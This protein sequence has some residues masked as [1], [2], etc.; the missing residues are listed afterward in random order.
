M[1]N[2]FLLLCTLLFANSLSAQNKTAIIGEFVQC[3]CDSVLIILQEDPVIHRFRQFSI[4]V[5]ENKFNADIAISEPSYFYIREG[6]RFITGLVEPGDSLA[7]EIQPGNTARI[8]A[9]SGRG[10]QKTVFLNDYRKFRLYDNV[11]SELGRARS[12]RFPFD[13]IIKFV[14][15]LE[16]VLLEKLGKIQSSMSHESFRLLRADI[17]SSAMDVKNRSIGLIYNESIEKTLAERQEELTMFSRN[18]LLGAFQFDSTL[19]FS[20]AYRNAVY[21]TLLREYS[22]LSKPQ[23]GESASERKY[24]FLKSNLPAN[25]LAAIGTLFLEADLPA[26]WYPSEISGAFELVYSRNED[27]VYKK[28]MTETYESFTSLREGS[29]APDFALENENGEVVT[30]E[31]FKG[32]VI[33]MDFWFGACG[34]CQANFQKTTMVKKYFANDDVVFLMVSI[35]GKNVWDDARKKENI[36][37]YHVFTQGKKAQHGVIKDYKVFTYPKTYIVDKNGRIFSANPSTD[38]LALKNQI[39]AALKSD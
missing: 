32:K 26:S 18:Y 35:D 22:N 4:P 12:S 28:Y 7:F 27:S 14:D 36:I 29:A 39:A 31:S 10:F 23:N 11:R 2:T 3:K 1:Q 38:A 5:I 30:L 21:Q 20:W 24:L 34:P 19:S 13:H 33:Y 37:G 17:A 6:T 15:S 25:M 9:V 16:Q 8:P